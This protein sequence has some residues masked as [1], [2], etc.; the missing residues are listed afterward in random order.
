MPPFLID[1][2]KIQIIKRIDAPHLIDASAFCQQEKEFQWDL[3]A[4]IKVWGYTLE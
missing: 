2:G 3:S 4:K 1:L